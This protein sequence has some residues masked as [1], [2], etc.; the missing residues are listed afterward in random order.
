[1]ETRAAEVSLIVPLN[2]K[3]SLG[4]LGGTEVMRLVGTSASST[5]Y[6]THPSIRIEIGRFACAEH[7]IK[8]QGFLNRACYVRRRAA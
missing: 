2:E 1:M 4:D 8:E 6:Q 5:S 3:N 7:R